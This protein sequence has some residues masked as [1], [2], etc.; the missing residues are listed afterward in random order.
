MKILVPLKVPFDPEM[1]K[2]GMQLAKIMGAELT[3]LSVCDTTPFKGYIKVQDKVLDHIRE[4]GEELLREA[5]E[6]AKNEGVTVESTIVEGHPDREILK[7]SE[8]ADM[9]VLQI[10]RFSGE[11]KVGSVTKELLE[12]SRTPIYVFKGEQREFNKLLVTLDDS[13]CAKEALEFSLI[14]AKRLGL[15]SIYS[16][17]VARSSD[18]AEAGKTVLN[19]AQKRGEE[20]DIKVDAH[21]D[22]GD[23]AK[24]IIKLSEG[25][26]LIIMGSTGQG[27]ISK[28]FL[29]S[30]ARK[31]TTFSA[32]DVIV[33][34][35]CR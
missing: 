7:A 15:E 6:L 3:F 10:S 18:R 9:L 8:G 31:V 25:F 33:V 19:E 24:E 12:Q 23:P 16:H 2:I 30:T 22:E 28:F 11:G 4:D 32:C 27:A 14:F 17:F 35:P 26:D 20:H 29:G 21:L 1:A 13:E 34:P 5:A